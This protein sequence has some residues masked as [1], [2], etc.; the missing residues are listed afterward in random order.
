M[1]YELVPLECTDQPPVAIAE[2]EVDLIGCHIRCEQCLAAGCREG[3]IGIECL[4]PAQQILGG[5]VY[6]AC[7][8]VDGWLKSAGRHPSV[9]IADRQPIASLRVAAVTHAQ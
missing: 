4:I 3:N 2:V 1:T 6:A 8:E 9:A 5:G 7:T